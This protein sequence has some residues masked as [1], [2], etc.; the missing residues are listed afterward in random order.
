[1]MR[2]R[3]LSC[4]VVL[5]CSFFVLAGLSASADDKKDKAP[6]GVWTL[7]G[8][9]TK[10]EYSDGKTVTISPHGDSNVI[11]II[12]EFTT[13]KDGLVNAKVTD[14]D[15]RAKEMVKDTLPV[16]T[17]FSFKWT[18]TDDAAKLADVKGEKVEQLKS[19]LEGEYSRKD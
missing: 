9:Q 13:G 18:V 10:F 2:A 17:E 8:G 19:H 12:C 5:A 15:G 7:N 4:G 14:L 6:S 16:G 3:T 1:M 11:A